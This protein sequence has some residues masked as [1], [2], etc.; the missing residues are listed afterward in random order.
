[1][2]TMPT[3]RHRSANLIDDGTYVYVY[4]AWN[5]LVKVR[6]KQDS[7]VTFQ[8]ANFDGLGRRMKKVVT[9]SGDQD[10]TVVYLYDGQKIIQANDGSDNMVQQFIH[11]TQYIDELVMVRVKDKGDLY[12]HQDANWNV[13]GLTDLGSHLVEHYKYSPYGE[14]TVD[15][16]DGFGDRDG[17]GKVDSTD[18][19][20]V[21]VTCTGTVSGACRILDLDFDGDYDSTDATKFD[22]LAQGLQRR[23]GKQS[24]GVAQPFAHQGLLFEPEIASYQNR[25]RQYDP[26]KRRFFQAD[27]ARRV[28]PLAEYTDGPNRYLY[29]VADP[30]RHGDPSGHA[31]TVVNYSQSTYPRYS[32][33]VNIGIYDQD[34]RGRATTMLAERAAQWMN[35]AWN[36]LYCATPL[37]SSHCVPVMFYFDVTLG[38]GQTNTAIIADSTTRNAAQTDGPFMYLSGMVYPI[39]NTPYV[40]RHEIGHIMGLQD[41]YDE[42]MQ[43]GECV[44]KPHP[45]HEHHQMGERNGNTVCHEALDILKHHGFQFYPCCTPYPVQSYTPHYA[46]DPGGCP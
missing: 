31:A 22:S 46:C 37:G 32:V 44:S 13:I 39:Y 26:A 17:D 45:G 23:P 24:T 14:L 34:N 3:K 29:S 16:D 12:V 15:Q 6:A 7:D 38:T 1:M 8:T 42:F 28:E 18:K 33:R 35:S 36:Q 40:W 4:D 11:G 10:A 27:S 20:T 2:N 43:G 9:N 25:A 30:A 5:R 21:G 41:D 19:G